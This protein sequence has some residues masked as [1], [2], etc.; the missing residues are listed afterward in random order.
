MS[1]STY[2]RWK[3]RKQSIPKDQLANEYASVPAVWF[4][5]C[6][7]TFLQTAGA[8]LRS[9]RVTVSVLPYENEVLQ[10]CGPTAKF[11]SI[12]GTRRHVAS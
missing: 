10:L 2:S 3:L 7:A 1:G 12:R 5:H 4:M 9:G 11:S 6:L 8:W